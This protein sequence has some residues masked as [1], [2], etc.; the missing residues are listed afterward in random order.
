MKTNQEVLCSIIKTV[1]MGQSGIRCVQDKASGQQLK[2][3]LSD[4][5]NE[6]DSIERQAYALA[7]RKGWLMEP[8][9]ASVERMSSIM[10]RMQL[11]GGEKDSKIAKMLVQGNT[12]GMIKG[13]KNLHHC[14]PLDPSVDA[15]AQKLLT[16]EQENIRQA[17]D[18]L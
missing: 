3:V 1:Q 7:T 5:L 2:Q 14:V 13:L 9:D 8:L 4:Q 15:I 16:R 6:Y 12:R 18:Y 17:C 11:M 10:A